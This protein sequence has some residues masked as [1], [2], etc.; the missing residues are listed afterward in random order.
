MV[1]KKKEIKAKNNPKEL[2]VDTIIRDEDGKE[3]D[4]SVKT[5]EVGSDTRLDA[6]KGEGQAITLRH[7]FFKPNQEE[8]KKRIPTAQELWNSHL[9]QMEIELWKDEWKPFYEIEPR[10]IF[11]DKF[12]IPVSYLSKKIEWYSFII[13]AIPAKGSLILETPRT[14]TEIA[15]E[16]GSVK[17]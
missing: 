2:G 11:Y 13:A 4:W 5:L 17:K 8:F 15:N 10:L 14:L 1:H 7:F 6:D 9:K 3:P 16:A 12:R